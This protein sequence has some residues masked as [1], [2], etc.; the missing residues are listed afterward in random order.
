MFFRLTVEFGR[1]RQEESDEDDGVMV[2]ES[3]G[4]HERAPIGF[5]VE[6]PW[7]DEEEEGTDGNHPALRPR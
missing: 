6:D 7:G 2:V 1:K 5:S 3:S 4:Q